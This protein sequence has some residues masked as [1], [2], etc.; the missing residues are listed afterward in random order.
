MVEMKRR[1]VIKVLGGAMAADPVAARAQ[2]G[3]RMRH[4]RAHECGPQDVAHRDSIAAFRQV[5]A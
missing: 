5:M 2:Q 4:R 3:E 1:E